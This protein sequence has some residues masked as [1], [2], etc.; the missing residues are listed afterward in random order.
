MTGAER[1]VF[2]SSGR[3]GAER[4]SLDHTACD[5]E[6]CRQVLCVEATGVG[7]RNGQAIMGIV[8]DVLKQS[9]PFEQVH[10]IA[11]GIGKGRPAQIVKPFDLSRLWHLNAGDEQAFDLGVELDDAQ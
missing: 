9:G 4:F 6:L 10:L 8:C 2:Q 11:L 3:G 7:N 5:G 1:A